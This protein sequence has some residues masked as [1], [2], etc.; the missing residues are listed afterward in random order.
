MKPDQI[1]VCRSHFESNLDT[2]L[3]PWPRVCCRPLSTPCLSARGCSSVTVCVAAKARQAEPSL[4]T[5]A[6]NV[7]CPQP[8]QE[9]NTVRTPAL[10]VAGYVNTSDILEESYHPVKCSI[11][12]LSHSIERQQ[13]CP[14]AAVQ[15]DHQYGRAERQAGTG[16]D[17]QTLWGETDGVWGEREGN[18]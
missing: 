16:E 18:R 2:G 13:N 15:T 7:Y 10:Q 1:P 3:W 17:S 9:R 6:F 4:R 14:F 11:W 5:A 8:T 12:L